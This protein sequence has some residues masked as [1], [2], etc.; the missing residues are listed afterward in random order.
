MILA[1]AEVIRMLDRTFP[2]LNDSAVQFY[3][4]DMS[5]KGAIFSVE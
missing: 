5:D 3:D 2:R 4:S 1:G